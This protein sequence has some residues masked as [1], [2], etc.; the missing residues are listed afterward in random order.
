MF[1]IHLQFLNIVIYCQ[2]NKFS[3]QKDAISLEHF[4]LFPSSF[5]DLEYPLF[6]RS[7]RYNDNRPGT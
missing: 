3:V 5:L 6:R 7:K 2:S 1:L 4:F